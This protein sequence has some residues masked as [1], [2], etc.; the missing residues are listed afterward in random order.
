MNRKK[1]CILII[2][3]FLFILIFPKKIEAKNR[4][5]SVSPAITETLFYFGYGDNIVGR[6][7]YC[8]YPEESKQIETIGNMMNPNFEK[9]IFLNPD[10]VIFQS[11]YDI[12]LKRQL[13]EMKVKT[14]ILPTPKNIKNILENYKI[15]LNIFG[16][17]K[18]AIDKLKILEQNIKNIEE[19]SNKITKKPKIYYSLG[20]GH[21]EYTAGKESF[22]DDVIRISGG[23][24]LVKEK[25]WSYPLEAL[26]YEQP[27][28]II[29]SK[30]N[31]DEMIKASKYKDLKALHN[32]KQIIFLEE[33]EITIPTPRMILTSLNIIQKAILEFSLSQ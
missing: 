24:N 33:D 1:K 9:M 8:N 13:E 32:M 26:I 22:I 17:E 25:G 23:V 2:I 16:N 5:I 29:T 21:I 20:S 15:I 4:I 18:T 7:M 31:Y 19:N 12:R 28:Y 10:I 3:M 11:H 30:K 6:T 27:D 14:L